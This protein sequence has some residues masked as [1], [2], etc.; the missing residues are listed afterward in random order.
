MVVGVLL[1]VLL[2]S[3]MNQDKTSRD[4]WCSSVIDNYIQEKTNKKYTYGLHTWH[5]LIVKTPFYS[6]TY[7]L[8]NYVYTDA[9]RGT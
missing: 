4:M 2:L 1:G 3:P 7:Y 5:F 6:L 9:K 8:Y